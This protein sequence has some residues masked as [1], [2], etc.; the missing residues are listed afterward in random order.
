MSRRTYHWW[1]L[2]QFALLI[3]CLAEPA[4]AAPDLSRSEYVDGILICPDSVRTDLYFHEPGKLTVVRDANGVPQI[5]LFDIRYL[6]TRKTANQ[7]VVFRRCTL[8]WEVRLLGPTLQQFTQI[9]KHL[10]QGERNVK[11]VSMSIERIETRIVAPFKVEMREQEHRV[12]SHVIGTPTGAKGDEFVAG[13]RWQF[14]VALSAFD[15]SAM[16]TALGLG[17]STVSLAYAVFVDGVSTGQNRWETSPKLGAPVGAVDSPSLREALRRVQAGTD[18]DD[19]EEQGDDVQLSQKSKEC[20]V[21]AEAVS[22]AVARE[23]LPVVLVEVDLNRDRIPPSYAAVDVY[24]FDFTSE[25][26]PDLYMKR[27]ELRAQSSG[28]RQVHHRLQFSADRPHVTAQTIRFAFAVTLAEPYSYRVTEILR[29]G[30]QRNSGWI[31]TETW[32]SALYVSRA[33]EH[34]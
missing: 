21:R 22:L 11:L 25:R 20:L 10:R 29:D 23:H 14:T 6:G 16:R 31:T 33:V 32:S 12:L 1:G 3:W 5:R 19:Q 27:I 2:P 18:M 13:K 4:Y 7:G 17:Q 8:T 24:C 9:R 28:G 34:H 26:A 15:T 30:S